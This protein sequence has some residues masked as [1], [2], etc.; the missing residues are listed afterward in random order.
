MKYTKLYEWYREYGRHDL[1]W[2]QTK[3]AYKIWISEIMLQQTQV[4]TVLERYYFPFLEKFPTLEALAN[5]SLDEVLKAWEGLGYYTRARNLHQ[6]AKL[7]QTTL[8]KTAQELEQLAGIGK[9]T[10]H[11]IASFAYGEA[12][13]ILD[14]NVKRILYRYYALKSAKPNELWSKSY[15]F[16]DKDNAY[17]FNQAMM[18]LGAMVCTSKNPNCTICPFVKECQGKVNPHNYPA[19]KAKKTK[20]IKTPYIVV[21]QKDNKLA[22]FQN[23]QRLLGGLWGFKQSDTKPHKSQKIGEVTHH[24]SHFGL[25][26]Q[27]VVSYD[28]IKHDHWFSLEEIS[29]LALS[30]VDRKVLALL[31]KQ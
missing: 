22:L 11:A 31:T 27:V 25:A 30:G 12:L 21:Y 8:P 3:D 19:K 20:P 4:K 18:D 29:Q 10:A 17:D 9:S 13:P 16:F 15:Q 2:R 7:C 5:A 28:F 23:N 6:S 24:Y 1:P 14:A 26:C